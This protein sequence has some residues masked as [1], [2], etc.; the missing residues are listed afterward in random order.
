MTD[1]KKSDWLRKY[2]KRKSMRKRWVKASQATSTGKCQSP[3]NLLAIPRPS[4]RQKQSKCIV[5][6]KVISVVDQHGRRCYT[7]REAPTTPPS[8][9]RNKASGDK[10]VR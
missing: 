9:Q 8:M 7:S 10:T 1:Y 4:L 5:S 2:T 6:D 3:I